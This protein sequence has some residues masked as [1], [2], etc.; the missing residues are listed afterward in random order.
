MPIPL[1]RYFRADPLGQDVFDLYTANQLYET[2][3]RN[4]GNLV[5]PGTS[6]NPDERHIGLAATRGILIF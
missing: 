6:T 2:V 5:I 3:L 1:F 4:K